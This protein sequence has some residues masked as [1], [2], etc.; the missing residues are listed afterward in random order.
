M[1]TIIP[2]LK[3]YALFEPMFYTHRHIG[4]IFQLIGCGIVARMQKCVFRCFV[5]PKVGFER[6]K[7]PYT[8]LL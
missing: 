6:R 8:R 3:K 5:A 2:V 7:P 1:D 4:L